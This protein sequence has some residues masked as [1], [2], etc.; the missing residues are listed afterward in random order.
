VCHGYKTRHADFDAVASHLGIVKRINKP[1]DRFFSDLVKDIEL[2]KSYF[3]MVEK[4]I[5]KLHELT[6]ARPSFQNS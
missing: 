6:G 2:A 4:M 1:R 5:S 3:G